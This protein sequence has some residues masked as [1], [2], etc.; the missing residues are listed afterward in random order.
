MRW[1]R[2]AGWTIG[3]LV[4]LVAAVMAVAAVTAWRSSSFRDLYVERSKHNLTA[5]ECQKGKGACN[6]VDGAPIGSLAEYRRCGDEV[7]GARTRGEPLGCSAHWVTDYLLRDWFNPGQSAYRQLRRGCRVHDLCYR[8][9]T[10][11]YGS[12]PG[13]CDGEFL[14]ESMRECRLIYGNQASFNWRRDPLRWGCQLRAGTAYLGVGGFRQV[15]YVTQYYQ[16]SKGA[17]CDYEGGPHAARD[18]VVSG[19]FLD[20]GLDYV[21]TL[22]LS[23]DRNAVAVRLLSFGSDGQSKEEKALDLSPDNVVVGDRE[24]AC[25]RRRTS[26]G[27]FTADCPERLGQSMFKQA[28]DWLRFAPVVVDSDGDGSDELVIPSVTSDFGLIF[29]HIRVRRERG[30][31][32][33]EPVRAYL[34]AARLATGEFGKGGCEAD[35]EFA[36]CDGGAADLLSNDKAMQNAGNQF[37]TIANLDAGCLAPNKQDIVLVSAFSEFPKQPTP[38]VV[39]QGGWDGGYIL[40]R[41]I[42]D[43]DARLWNMRRDK[44]NN[45][46]HRLVGCN[47]PNPDQFQTHARLQYPAF[48]LRVP[49]PKAPSVILPQIKPAPTGTPTCEPDERV[50]VISRDK[51][52]TSTTSSKAGNLNDVDLMLYDI[53][54]TYLPSSDQQKIA[55]WPGKGRDFDDLRMASSRWMPILW[56]ETADPILTSRAAREQGIAMVATFIGGKYEFDKYWGKENG[57]PGNHPVIAVLR[58]E[59]LR[60]NKRSWQYRY[61][62]TMGQVPDLYGVFKSTSFKQK[63]STLEKI[64]NIWDPRRYGVVEIYY[65]I[66]T[67]LAPFNTL[68]GKGVSVVFF[69]NRTMWETTKNKAK[70][71]LSEPLPIEQGRFRLMIVPIPMPGPIYS[72][73]ATMIDCPVAAVADGAAKP[74]AP[75]GNPDFLRREPVLAGRF[76]ETDAGGSLAVA[77]RDTTGGIRLTALRYVEREKEWRFGNQTCALPREEMNENKKEMNKDELYREKLN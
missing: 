10:V 43:N 26:E 50:A 74:A 55:T 64:F 36:N 58:T 7:A 42:F 54:S 75:T 46:N 59:Q 4:L 9:G 16:G 72:G 76:F 44:F 56:P 41:F 19:R 71:L 12:G 2:W 66:P 65:H 20:D 77:W 6:L 32:G 68:G 21:V 48:A 1:L 30:V 31:I 38:E 18:Q 33:F 11:T 51:C 13:Q 63:D 27:G 28:A 29:T 15:P 52:P 73:Q 39:E 24:W 25:Q 34:G 70:M 61:P 14:A 60:A 67:V 3:V 17:V 5:A 8:H 57:R 53:N 45:D 35:L 22:T 37:I 40:R 62:D 49:G 23:P 69:A 47:L